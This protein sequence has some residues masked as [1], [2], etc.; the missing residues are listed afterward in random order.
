MLLAAI[1]AAALPAAVRDVASDTLKVER[2][3]VLMRHGVRPPTKAPAMPAGVA[4]RPWPSWP[5]AP[6]WLTPHGAA[7]VRL[8]AAADRT[9]FV[10]GGLMP[11]TGCPRTDSVRLVADSDER[12]IATAEAYRDALLPHCDA[13]IEHRPEG[14]H[15]PLFS[16]VGEDA[17]IDA[18][19]ARDAVLA[20]AGPGG[21]AAV[22]AEVRP[23]LARLDA[24]LCGGAAAGCGVAAEPGALVAAKDGRAKLT[25]SLDRGSTAAQILLLEYAEGKPLAEVGWGRASGADISRLSHLHALEFALLARP[26]PLARRNMALLA[27]L[28]R[29]AIVADRAPSIMMIAGHD[30]NV[31]SLAGLIGVHW[32]VPG[33]ATDDPAPGGAL[34][35][36]RLVDRQGRRF[37]RVVYRSQTLDQMRSLSPLTGSSGPV[38]QALPIAGCGGATLCPITRFAALLEDGKR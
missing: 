15:D 14:E 20:A 11:A 16:P 22:E 9:G 17:P 13:A 26:L 18:V 3:V 27:P 32:T 2:V 38:R 28:I 19:T 23:D 31:A 10:A 24:I 33:F 34:M 1:A 30:T 35:L 8:V 29:D 5:V 21:I 37:V 6:G 7:A 4:A 12:T 25:G 36:E